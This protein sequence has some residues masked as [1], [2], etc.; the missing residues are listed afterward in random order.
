MK[1]KEVIKKRDL[2]TFIR[3]PRS[4]YH[5]SPYYVPALEEDERKTL[6]QHPALAF[7]DLRLWLAF[8]NGKPVGR[9]AGIINRKCNLL[10]NQ[11]RI[12]FGWFDAI[13]DPEV[14]KALMNEVETW[15]RSENLTEISGPSRF[16]NMEKQGM[17]VMGFDKMPSI[18]SE[19]NYEYY[20]Q[21][22][23]Q[24]GFQ[25]EVDYIQYQVKVNEIPERLKMLN[26]IIQRKYKVHIKGIYLPKEL[27][28]YGKSF[29]QPSIE[30]FAPY[31][32]LFPERR[33]DYYHIK[34]NWPL[35]IKI[36]C[37]SFGG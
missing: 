17:L 36:L 29:L 30:V 4:L 16:S 15:G 7:C 9:I 13:D 21:F 11:Q 18:S 37:E 19:Y 22:I 10:K 25:K 2:N 32:I 35:P 3:F 5:K 26:E 33:R 14:T 23:E 6:T 20:P 27:T 24:L 12:R 34:N 31:T 8:R 28:K 1:S